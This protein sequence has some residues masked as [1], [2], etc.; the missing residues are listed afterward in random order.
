MDK[1]ETIENIDRVVEDIMD[2]QSVIDVIGHES[3][4]VYQARFNQFIIELDKV[5]VDLIDISDEIG[6]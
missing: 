3:D 4:H 6:D 5:A 2:I 1:I